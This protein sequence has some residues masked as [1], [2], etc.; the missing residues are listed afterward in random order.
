[1]NLASIALFDYIL[2]AVLILFVVHGLWVGFLRQLPFAISLVGSY[3]AAGQYAGD[4]M[5]HLAQITQNPKIVFGVSFLVLLI[6]ATLLL[7]LIGKLIGK[8][9]QVKVVGWGNRIFL[10]APLALAKAVMLVVLVVMFWAASLPPADH[11]FRDSLTASYLEQGAG[12]ARS[13]I[14]DAGIKKALTP[15]KEAHKPSVQKK[16]TDKQEQEQAVPA[17]AAPA[18]PRQS[19]QPS[20]AG[21]DP[22][23]STEIITH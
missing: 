14:R 4:L 16:V 13:L 22:A 10:G 20:R 6:I 7:K 9:I 15:R 3:W 1:M 2:L 12:M 17:P 21:D 18:Q 8:I 19:P 11:F 23:S 5:P